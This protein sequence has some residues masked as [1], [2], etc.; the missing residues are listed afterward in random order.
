M[1]SVNAEAAG[2]RRQEQRVS[3]Y[4]NPE[5]RLQGTTQQADAGGE[6]SYRCTCDHIIAYVGPRVDKGHGDGPSTV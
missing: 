1:D 5:A 2:R 4:S 6:P 3:V